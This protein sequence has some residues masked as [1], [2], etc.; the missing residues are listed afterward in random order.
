MIKYLLIHAALTFVLFTAWV[1]NPGLPGGE[2][3]M[4]PI[5][6]A[7]ILLIFLV[8]GSTLSLLFRKQLRNRKSM[9]IGFSIHLLL[10]QVIPVLGEEPW[11]A[12]IT[13]TGANG[14]IN[15]AFVFVPVITGFM[16]WII[17]YFREPQQPKH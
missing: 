14:M 17:I 10:I 16:T 1:A 4:A 13:D 15:R 9:T 6:M 8:S 5:G 7:L 11:L 3:G 12:G 2:I